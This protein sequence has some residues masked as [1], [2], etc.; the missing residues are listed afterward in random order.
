M[1]RRLTSALAGFALALAGCGGPT[2]PAERVDPD[3]TGTAGTAEP[4]EPVDEPSPHA[5]VEGWTEL[6]DQPLPEPGRAELTI[7]GEAI[8]LQ[9]QC[10]PLGPVDDNDDDVLFAFR[11]TGTGTA[12]DG[13]EVRVF[14]AR[15]VMTPEAARRSAAVYDY[16]GQERGRIQVIAVDPGASRN[17]AT[18]ASPSLRDPAGTSL[19]VLHV[20]ESGAFTA[21][22]DIPQ[23]GDHDEALSGSALLAGRC[24]A[25][26][27]DD[28]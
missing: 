3:P 24:Q 6:H 5:G 21:D 7:A 17:D 12:A 1:P 10:H 4:G 8:D 18:V 28:E 14:G 26:W 20:D 13:R 22:V 25:A 19:P 27:P 9:V 11:F 16:D 2:P 15:E 23:D